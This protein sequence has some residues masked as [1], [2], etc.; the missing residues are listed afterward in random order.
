MNEVFTDNSRPVRKLV[1]TTLAILA[2]AGLFCLLLL[3]VVRLGDYLQPVLGNISYLLAFILAIV[4][5][6]IIC[7]KIIKPVCEVKR[8]KKSRNKN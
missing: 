2:I 7:C 3:S 8:E 4:A 6:N 5:V 1:M